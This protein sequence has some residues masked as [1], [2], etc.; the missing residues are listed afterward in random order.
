[1]SYWNGESGH[2]SYEDALSMVSDDSVGLYR[3]YC[4]HYYEEHHIDEWLYMILEFLFTHP[5]YISSVV[6]LFWKDKIENMDI[7]RNLIER[8]LTFKA[9]NS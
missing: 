1:M 7:L 5:F 8:F 2:E 3:K 4:T 6:L 9:E